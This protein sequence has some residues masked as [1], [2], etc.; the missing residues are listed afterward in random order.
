MNIRQQLRLI[1]SVCTLLLTASLFA[2]TEQAANTETIKE[3]KKQL[4][5]VQIKIGPNWNTDKSP[6]EQAYF[7]E[8]S[9][10]LQKHR[11]AGHIVMGARYSDIGLIIFSADSVETV[12]AYMSED[13][14]I[15]S[16]TFQYEV[17]AMNVFY[18]GM[19]KP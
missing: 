6:G 19:V 2:A 3:L 4:F 11:K 16:G 13:P 14:S 9:A 7:R 12:K 1:L 15:S 18:P 10:N 8:H 17:H 5:A